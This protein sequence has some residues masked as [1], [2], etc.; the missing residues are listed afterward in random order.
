MR[1]APEAL[2]HFQ[3]GAAPQDFVTATVKQELKARFI[4]TFNPKRSVHR[5]LRR[6]CAIAHG[7]PLGTCALDDAVVAYPHIPAPSRAD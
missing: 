5:N 6:A 1:L 4:E 7:I 2:C 3:P